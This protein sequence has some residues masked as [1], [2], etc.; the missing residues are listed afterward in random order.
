MSA[1]G[2]DRGG[3]WRPTRSAVLVAALGLIVA[4]AVA[5]LAGSSPPAQAPPS[6][7]PTSP[8]GTPRP[9]GAN[10]DSSPTTA[11]LPSPAPAVTDDLRA[12]LRLLGV[13]ATQDA[14]PRS[15]V[16]QGFA[17]LSLDRAPGRSVRTGELVE[18]G[19]RLEEVRA[20][21]AVVVRTATGERVVLDVFEGMPSPSGSPGGAPVPRS[22][23]PMPAGAAAKTL[24]TDGTP[25]GGVLS[26]P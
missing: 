18:P 12:R 13:V 16:G 9:S 10:I 19:L 17:L 25:G 22:A 8:P 2:P 1:S 24:K 23:A 21:A 11:S 4:G 15:N 5:W 6:H 26:P 7:T 14:G 3:A 20:S